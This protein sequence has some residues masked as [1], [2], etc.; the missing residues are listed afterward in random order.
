MCGYVLHD[1]VILDTYSFNLSIRLGT[2][3][4]WHSVKETSQMTRF[5]RKLGEI[6]ASILWNLHFSLQIYQ[7]QIPP[8]TQLYSVYLRQKIAET[9]CRQHWA[10]ASINLKIWK[11]QRSFK[12]ISPK[13]IEQHLISMVQKLCLLTEQCLTFN[14]VLTWLLQKQRLGIFPLWGLWVSL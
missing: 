11:K 2:Y 14:L 3:H 6:M 1:I 7:S 8:K 12:I 4:C 10:N 9:T 5:S 13:D